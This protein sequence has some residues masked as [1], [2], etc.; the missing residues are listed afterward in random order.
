MQPL[1]VIHKYYSLLLLHTSTLS[2]P[3]L[4]IQAFPAGKG[5][6]ALLDAYNAA[7]IQLVDA[8]ATEE[9]VASTLVPAAVVE[10]PP[11]ESSA[12][13]TFRQVS[14][15]HGIPSF[16]CK[17]EGSISLQPTSRCIS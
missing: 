14:N 12:A 10:C 5:S 7:L 11:A 3:D 4:C 6:D 9:L 15:N 13:I 8:G 16:S 2:V 1:Y 17:Q